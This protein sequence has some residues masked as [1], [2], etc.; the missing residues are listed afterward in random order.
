MNNRFHVVKG[1]EL[2]GIEP[3]SREGPQVSFSSLVND[4]RLSKAVDDYEAKGYRFLNIGL[5]MGVGC[6]VL[7]EDVDM[8]EG[9]SKSEMLAGLEDENL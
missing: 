3:D 9:D 8:N 2:L 7:F 4:G 6:E 5:F 1:H